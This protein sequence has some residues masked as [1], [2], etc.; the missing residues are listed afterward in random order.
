MNP[1]T[2][3][4]P[5]H[6]IPSEVE[7][8]LQTELNIGRKDIRS[9]KKKIKKLR[10][11]DDKAFMDMLRT[12]SRNHYQMNQMV[13]RK[14][15]NMISVNTVMLTLVVGGLISSLSFEYV[16]HY[17]LLTFSAF[18]VASITFAM[19]AMSPERTHGTLTKEDVK[20]KKGN[21][22]FFGNFKNLTE[23]EYENAMIEMVNDRD[24]VYRSMIQDIYYLGQVLE[25]KRFQ[26][27]MS[28]FLFTAGFVLMLTMTFLFTM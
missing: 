2:E 13:D 8:Y 19:L 18:S 5:P 1:T 14:S 4:I 3:N 10:K 7:E 12:T 24:F 9:L 17:S 11:R 6:S 28:Q 20:K 15:R 16:H 26:L 25:K 21:P 27:R 23:Q 22:L